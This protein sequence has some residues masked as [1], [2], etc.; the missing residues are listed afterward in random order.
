MLFYNGKVLQTSNFPDRT[1]SLRL[2]VD[3]QAPQII[4]WKYESE[5]E[6]SALYY[7]T[8]HIQ[9]FGLKVSLYMPYIPNARMDRV[10]NSDEIFTLKYF[11]EF[12]NSLNFHE[13][14]VVDP[15]SSVSCAL[16]DNLKVDN[17][18]TYILSV[19][20]TI[21]KD[22]NFVIFYPDEGSMK[23]Y[24]ELINHI[25]YSF[26][27]KKRDWRTG[28]IQGL[29][30]INE[31]FVKDKDVLIIDDI[32]SKGGTFYHSAKALKEAGAKDIYLYVTHCENTIFYGEL[33]KDNGL[34]K[35][36]Y[37][38]SSIPLLPHTK[39]TVLESR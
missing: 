2:E 26:G 13:V 24:S 11:A 28:K 4:C 23:R 10:K 9:S 29:T 5:A 30:L 17:A 15:H 16:I 8:K 38:T 36:I 12:I 21:E 35:H 6:M 14:Y 20:A 39:I 33:L 32:C 31:N 27:V 37:T 25:P 1:L 18:V 19:I 34:I 7:V 22:S 3:E